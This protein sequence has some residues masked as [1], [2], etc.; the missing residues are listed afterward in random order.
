LHC[1]VKAEH[2]ETVQCLLKWGADPLRKNE[3][4]KTPLDMVAEG[5][6]EEIA[7]L[8]REAVKRR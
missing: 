7:R 4:W 3:E 1:A 6:S 5:R 8:L 2:V